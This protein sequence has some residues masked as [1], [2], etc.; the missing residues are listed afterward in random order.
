MSVE[1]DDN[2]RRVA[3]FTHD[4]GNIRVPLDGESNPLKH[5]TISPPSIHEGTAEIPNLEGS[6]V[7][8][9]PFPDP[10]RAQT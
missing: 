2:G 4:N 5:A 8:K 7:V 3:V 1:I 9:V 6:G 10:N